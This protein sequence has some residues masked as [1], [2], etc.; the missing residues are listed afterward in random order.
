[1]FFLYGPGE[2]PRR[3]VP[4]VA[5]ALHA[6]ERAKVTDGTQVRDFLHV[7]DAAR[8]FVALL[9]SDVAGAVNIGSGTGVSLRHIVETLERLAGR[10]NAVAFGAIPT[11][12]DEPPSIVADITKLK[13]TGW[14]QHVSL[15][16][17]LAQAIENGR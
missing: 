3:L 13:T 1:M 4:S 6:G 11:R 8:A 2:D 14:R 9:M 10:R 17:G 12:P 15:D 16:D 7:T 5:R